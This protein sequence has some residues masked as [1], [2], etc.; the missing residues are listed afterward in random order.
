MDQQ[1]QAAPVDWQA[2]V[3]RR[4]RELKQVGEARHQAEQ[5]RDCAYRELARLRAGEED[6]WD[7]AAYPTPG[8]W[9]ARFNNATPAERHDAAKWAIEDSQRASNCFLMAHEKRLNEQRS[10]EAAIARVRALG[11]RWRYTGDRKGTALPELLAAL[12]EPKEG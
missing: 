6:G 8:Q 1:E 2:V 7:P 4:E 10:A 3:Q 12:D 5:E 11:E 9:I